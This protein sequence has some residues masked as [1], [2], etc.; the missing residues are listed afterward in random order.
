MYTFSLRGGFVSLLLLCRPTPSLTVLDSSAEALLHSHNDEALHLLYRTSLQSHAWNA[1]PSDDIVLHKRRFESDTPPSFLSDADKLAF[2]RHECIRGIG[3]VNAPPEIIFE[4]FRDNAKILEFNSNIQGIRDIFAFPIR[5]TE[6][7]ATWTKVSWSKASP[8][9]IPF[10]K[11]REFYSIVSFTKFKNGTY[12]IVNRPAYPL[13]KSK[14]SQSVR[15]SL[16]LS[17]NIIEPYQNRTKITQI[18]HINP[19]GSAD[20]A[21]IAWIINRRQLSSYVF[22]K[23]LEKVVLAETERIQL[24]QR[25]KDQIRGIFSGIKSAWQSRARVEHLS[26]SIQRIKRKQ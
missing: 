22:I 3:I 10:V 11:S 2:R 26:L 21:A 8:K 6:D 23:S 12:V 18:I 1:L 9:N 15:G 4:A 20:T 24:I 14:D 19:G 25:S 16:L 17:G 13:G 7:S 5:V